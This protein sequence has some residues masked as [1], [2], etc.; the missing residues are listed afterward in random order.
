MTAH[1]IRPGE[2]RR[3]TICIWLLRDEERSGLEPVWE[4]ARMPWHA[5]WIDSLQTFPEDQHAE[6]V[7]WARAYVAV[8][9]DHVFAEDVA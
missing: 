9:P 1:V 8:H 5:D 4:V 2:Y 6:A 3:D 7:I